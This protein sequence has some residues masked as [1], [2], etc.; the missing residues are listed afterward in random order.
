MI[1]IN[2]L[3]N[4]SK[5]ELNYLSEEINKE[6][7]RRENQKAQKIVSE[8]NKLIR[9][10]DDLGGS[11]WSNDNQHSFVEVSLNN[12]GDLVFEFWD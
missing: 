9:K 4:M 7:K 3:Q 12:D 2:D 11:Y 10:A 8:F 5:E 6:H 1:N